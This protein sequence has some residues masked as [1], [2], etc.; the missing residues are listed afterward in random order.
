MNEKT[1]V[2]IYMMAIICNINIKAHLPFLNQFVKVNRN[3]VPAD[4][5]CPG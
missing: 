1:L 2:N 5:R 4:L 3:S